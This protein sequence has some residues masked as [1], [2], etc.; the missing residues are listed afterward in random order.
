MRWRAATRLNY[1]W[2]LRALSDNIRRK[3]SIVEGMTY[4]HM[5]D[6]SV[7]YNIHADSEYCSR[8][9]ARLA[10][11]A[12]DMDASVIHGASSYYNGLAAAEAA[13]ILECPFIYEIRGLWQLSQQVY[14]PELRHSELKQYM[15][16]ME[17]TAAFSA[18]GIVTISTP[19]KNEIRGWGI[20]DELIRVVPNCVDLD[21]FKPQEKNQ[22]LKSVLG[23]DKGTFVVGYLGSM[24][25]YEGIE[26]IIEAVKK[27]AQQGMDIV[28]LLAGGGYAADHYNKLAHS[29]L[30]PANLRWIGKINF[31]MMP[32]YYSILDA[33]AYP[34]LDFEVCRLVPPLKPLEA[35]AMKVP[36]I[37]AELPPCRKWWKTEN[38]PDCQSE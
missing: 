6:L 30:D 28:L 7:G 9:G 1:P 31:N 16:Y 5:E 32:T 24:T 11:I 2:D 21:L 35:M 36:V 12:R 3:F 37:V 27:L 38:R 26:L 8:Y 20:E 4:H 33:C 18:H 14:N 15:D 34:R 19:L 10:D 25:R 17:R 29:K 22:Q 23:L 13:R